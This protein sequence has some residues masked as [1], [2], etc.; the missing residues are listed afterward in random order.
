MIKKDVFVVFVNPKIEKEFESLKEGKFEDKKLYKYIQ[1]A[2]DDLKQNSLSGTK[3]PKDLWPNEYV[4]EYRIDNLWKYDL[5][6]AWRLI[7]TI[8]AENIRIFNVLLEWF[9]HKEYE[10]RFGY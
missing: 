2:I 7:Y 5:P 6:N 3:I 1:R 10:R 4:K 9:D 8:H